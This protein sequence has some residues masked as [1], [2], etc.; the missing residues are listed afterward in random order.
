MRFLPVPV[1]SGNICPV[2]ANAWVF[3]FPASIC[4]SPGLGAFFCLLCSLGSSVGSEK[5]RG[6]QFVQFFTR[7]KGGSNDLSRTLRHD[8]EGTC[9]VSD[10]TLLKL[11]RSLSQST[12]LHYRN[13]IV[14]AYL[15]GA[16]STNVSTCLPRLVDTC[17]L[18]LTLE[19]CKVL[20]HVFI[21]CNI[22][23]F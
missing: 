23:F 15:A 12:K 18:Y 8:T 20:S 4:F 21:T 14:S 11:Y 22:Y 3:F 1:K 7:G 16:S 2:S 13:L 5:A 6:L 19:I 9:E 10:S 17:P